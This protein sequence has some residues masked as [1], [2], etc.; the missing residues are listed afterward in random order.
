MS[1]R[2]KKFNFV[3]WEYTIET[4]I[5]KLLRHHRNARWAAKSQIFSTIG[6]ASTIAM[7]VIFRFSTIDF[8]L[9]LIFTSGSL[10]LAIPM[11][12]AFPIMSEIEETLRKKGSPLPDNLVIGDKLPLWVM[13]ML[14]WFALA[15]LIPWLIKGFT[16]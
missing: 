12:F 10:L 16:S 4:P 9:L 11:A 6:M 5:E 15:I 13:R 14:F 2:K 8:V 7:G 1:N 3:L